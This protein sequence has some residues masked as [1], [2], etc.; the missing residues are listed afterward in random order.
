MSAAL[1]AESAGG[2]TTE[3]RVIAALR[4]INED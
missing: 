3:E 1:R 4:I 2:K